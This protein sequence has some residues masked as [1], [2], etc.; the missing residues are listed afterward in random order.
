MKS[1]G[2]SGLVA[3]ASNPTF[4]PDGQSIA[5]FEAT[6]WS[7]VIETVAVSG[8]TPSVL[9]RLTYPPFGISWT[10][11][12]ILFARS[13]DKD[14]KGIVQ[15]SPDGATERVLVATGD[16]SVQRPQMLPDD[17]TILFTLATGLGPDR[18]DT[19]HTHAVSQIRHAHDDRQRW[20][21]SPLSAYGTDPHIVLN[22]FEE[23]K[24]RP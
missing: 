17:D 2:A 13:F 11:A 19:A 1:P 9:K 10:A 8:G 4:S 24:G 20:R 18:W 16:E 7:G 5:Y 6:D 21:R 22:W 23:L 3:W 15:L 14:G 12:G